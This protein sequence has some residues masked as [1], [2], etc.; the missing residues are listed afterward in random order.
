[1]KKTNRKD[2]DL[3]PIKTDER[4]SIPS[5][6]LRRKNPKRI[7]PGDF[8][9]IEVKEEETQ[10]V[11]PLD[12][13]NKN[14]SQAWSLTLRDFWPSPNFPFLPFPNMPHAPLSLFGN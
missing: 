2:T 3:D 4:G 5:R 6:Y 13:H 12:D 9:S 10:V 8:S 11:E 14:I 7:D 1:M